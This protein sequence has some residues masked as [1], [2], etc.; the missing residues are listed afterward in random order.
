MPDSFVG[1]D[2]TNLDKLLRTK[3]RVVGPNTVHE[4]FVR[5]TDADNRSGTVVGIADGVTQTLVSFN[6]P[7]DYRLWGFE[8]TGGA[9]FVELQVVGVTIYSDRINLV[10]PKGY[11]RLPV[12]EEITAGQQVRLQITNESGAISDFR[13]VVFGE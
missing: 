12:P 11:L 9:C 2:E 3:T 10:R 6:A 8:A 1:V 5:Q 7:A 13:G 4:E